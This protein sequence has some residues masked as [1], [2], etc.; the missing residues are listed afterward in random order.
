MHL[1]IFFHCKKISLFSL[2]FDLTVIL[3][4]TTPGETVHLI[5]FVTGVAIAIHS[6]SVLEAG[7]TAPILQR[8]EQ[9]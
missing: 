1:Y 4:C 6:G 3:Y 5:V 8:T 9:A 2:Y 7:V